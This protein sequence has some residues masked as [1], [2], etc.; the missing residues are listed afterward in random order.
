[1]RFTRENSSSIHPGVAISLY[2]KGHRNNAGEIY[3]QLYKDIESRWGMEF[4]AR[5]SNGRIRRATKASQQ[6]E[7][8]SLQASHLKRHPIVAISRYSNLEGDEVPT[9]FSLVYS[10]LD[11]EL[12]MLLF[13]TRTAFNGAE[14]HSLL[15]QWLRELPLFCGSVS[16]ACAH[17]GSAS[18]SIRYSDYISARAAFPGHQFVP[19]PPISAHFD[20][21]ANWGEFTLA[22][23]DLLQRMAG[24]D[25]VKNGAPEGF[26]VEFIG[27]N[28]IISASDSLCLSGDIS[29]ATRAAFRSLADWLRPHMNS[30]YAKGFIPVQEWD[31]L[32]VDWAAHT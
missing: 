5:N 18:D 28:A 26:Q 11:E 7:L 14:V 24:P 9:Y 15:R 22:G 32:S 1:M 8:E 10:D 13:L 17:A 30:T 19:H 21:F 27:G 6:K 20:G 4:V 31:R 23:P 2:A 25:V 12:S 29:D 3:S 16:P